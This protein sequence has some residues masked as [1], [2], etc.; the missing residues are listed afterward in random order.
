M[1]VFICTNYEQTDKKFAK[2]RFHS[3]ILSDKMIVVVINVSCMAENRTY[4]V[5]IA[6]FHSVNL[7]GE[8]TYGKKKHFSLTFD[9]KATAQDTFC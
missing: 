5:I 6:Q 1:H 3:R 8:K 9:S 4:C 2:H 7:F